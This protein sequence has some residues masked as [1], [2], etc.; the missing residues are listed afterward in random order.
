MKSFV[1]YIKGGFFIYLFLLALVCLSGN[2]KKRKRGGE[3]GGGKK[4]K[5]KK[6]LHPTT[7]NCIPLIS[8]HHWPLSVASHWPGAPD[9]GCVFCIGG[10]CV[11]C[12]VCGSEESLSRFCS[13]LN[14][15]IFSF[16]SS[17]D[18]ILMNR[19][20]TYLALMYNSTSCLRN[21]DG[22][23]ITK[24]EHNNPGCPL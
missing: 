7:I 6:P 11:T 13:T 24:A 14:A 17:S 12:R 18:G 2:Y 3:K 20:S 10:C 19:R 22:Q 1:K 4:K 16:S 5:D 23:K 21:R 9:A 15:M 8:F